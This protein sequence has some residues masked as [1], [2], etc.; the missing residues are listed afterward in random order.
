MGRCSRCGAGKPQSRVHKW[1]V[2]CL[3]D[4]K[5]ERCR[6]AELA[7]SASSNDDLRATLESFTHTS[8]VGGN[9]VQYPLGLEEPMLKQCGLCK[10][11]KPLDD[12]WQDT[13]RRD[14]KQCRCKICSNLHRRKERKDGGD[15]AEENENATQNEE[16]PRKR[17]KGE[18]L[19]VFKN[20]RLPEY[21]I[22]RSGDTAARSN[23]LEASQNFYMLR[24]AIFEGKGHLEDT[25]R[26][27]LAYCI[28]PVEVAKGREWHACS[29]Q[30]A[31]AAIGQAIE[32]DNAQR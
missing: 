28:L 11:Y 1:C 14:G 25:V 2:K 26:E 20:S 10:N 4:Y 30:T 31:L 29:L 22:G 27:M 8:D 13:S 9:E 3:W 23:G 7:N 15:D 5:Q 19:Y 18:D 24:V 17:S 12:F 6:M 32:N 16:P 21:K